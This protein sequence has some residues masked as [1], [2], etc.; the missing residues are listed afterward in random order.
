MPQLD[1]FIFVD[2]AFLVLLCFIFMYFI[3]NN[4]ILPKIISVLKFRTKF[5]NNLEFKSLIFFINGFLFKVELFD[6][7]L[8]C[9]QLLSLLKSTTY[10]FNIV[11][12]KS[13]KK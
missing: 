8:I 10:F 7:K 3:N 4:L 12:L 13:I 1:K 9:M 5:L 6:S 11:L 2:N